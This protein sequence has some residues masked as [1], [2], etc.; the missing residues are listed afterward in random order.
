MEV[1]I[2]KEELLNNPFKTKGNSSQNYLE[3]F[4]PNQQLILEHMYMTLVDM[5]AWMLNL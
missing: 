3:M 5:T 1:L 2:F 4:S